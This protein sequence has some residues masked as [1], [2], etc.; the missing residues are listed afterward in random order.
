MERKTKCVMCGDWAPA[1]E[2]VDGLCR[3]CE[4]GLARGCD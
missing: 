4:R 3:C 1:E 2:I